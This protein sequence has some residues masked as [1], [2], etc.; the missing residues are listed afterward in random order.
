M[1]PPSFDS[2]RR[3]LQE[4]PLL[5]GRSYRIDRIYL[6]D[7]E[8]NCFR[9]SL[10]AQ[11]AYK[12][13]LAA[14]R[15][16]ASLFAEYEALRLLADQGTPWAGQV[17]EFRAETP[18]YLISEYLPGQSLDKS[19]AWLPHAPLIQRR[20]ERLL[21]D[22]H[23][24]SDDR[25][26]YLPHPQ[27]ATWEEL[28]DSRLQYYFAVLRQGGE[29]APEMQAAANYLRTAAATALQVVRSA[30]LHFDVK[31]A[32]IIFDP[33]TGNTA[34]ID[35]E[36]SRF[37]DRDFEFIKVEC[38]SRRWPDYRRLIASGLAEEHFARISTTGPLRAKWL[39]YELCH[40]F[41]LLAYAVEMQIP[42]PDYR[43]AEIVDLLARVRRLE[44]SAE[45]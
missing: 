27:F 34:L 1:E 7:P 32:N 25:F 45:R 3:V 14:S 11:P 20:L 30:F 35:F 33:D 5:R 28:V 12:L 39:L 42:V 21:A 18:A 37:G 26:G 41:S 10:A 24:I 29:L 9:L 40:V 15:R 4:S 44:D 17:V 38:L 6:D 2:I 23:R 36:L 13:R 31:P 19:N 43:R 8:E 16:A 22:L